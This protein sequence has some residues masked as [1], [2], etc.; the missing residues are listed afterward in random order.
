[1][2]VHGLIIR[3]ALFAIIAIIANLA[4][5][6]VILSQGDRID[7]FVIA[8]GAGTLIGLITKFLL[9]KYWIFYDKSNGAKSYGKKFILYSVTGLITT[10]IFWGMETTFW[11]IW[12]TDMMREIG[13]IIGLSIGYLV[14]YK[15]DSRF[16]FYNRPLQIAS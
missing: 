12:E 5:Q 16:V 15:L 6:R 10:M 14:K 2:T 13:A 9:D 11:L 3:Y 7:I 1:M 8:V 4:T